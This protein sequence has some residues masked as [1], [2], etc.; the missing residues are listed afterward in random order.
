MEVKENGKCIKE[1][2]MPIFFFFFLNVSVWL[3]YII[4]VKQQWSPLNGNLA[5][6]FPIWSDEWCV[7]CKLS[8]IGS[9]LLIS[10]CWH[11]DLLSPVLLQLEW[12]LFHHLI[13]ISS[14]LC[15]LI[16]AHPHPHPH[17]QSKLLLPTALL[18]SNYTMD[19]YHF[20]LMKEPGLFKK[21]RDVIFMGTR[22]HF[23]LSLCPSR[24]LCF[25]HCHRWDTSHSLCCSLH[26]SI[27]ML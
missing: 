18:E 2:C 3:L 20:P 26:A 1:M 11:S 12:L 10:E 21:N 27:L 9:D 25:T 5:V 24:R 4:L 14:L 22:R 8:H 13:D 16:P 17:P 19:V 6:G 15:F 7:M 23:H